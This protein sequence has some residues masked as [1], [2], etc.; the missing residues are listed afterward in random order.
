V[1]LPN[2]FTDN[3]VAEGNVVESFAG[4]QTHGIKTIYTPSVRLQGYTRISSA[5]KRLTA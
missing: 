2:F 3:I 5:K 1:E 4:K